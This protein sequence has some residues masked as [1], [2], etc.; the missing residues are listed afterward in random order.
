MQGRIA[1]LDPARDCGQIETTDGRLIY[2]HRN[3][4]EDDRYDTL[5]KGDTVELG[6]DHKDADEGPHASIV[7][8]IGS[9]RFTDTP[10]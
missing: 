7:R 8:L 9:L 10:R 5:E 1:S 4:V 2:F 6:V 3:A